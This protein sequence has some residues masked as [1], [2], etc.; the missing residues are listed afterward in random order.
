MVDYLRREQEM[1]FEVKDGEARNITVGFLMPCHSTPW[2]SHLVYPH[3]NAWAL[4]CEPPLHLSIAERESYLD[5]ADVFY[6]DPDLWLNANMK[7]R[8]DFEM[9]LL[10]DHAAEAAT[11]RAWPE[12]VVFF[13]QLEP[14]IQNVLGTSQ[15]REC[16]R[17]FNTHWH[18][19]WRRKGDIIVWCTR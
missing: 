14:T 10:P 17:G 12:Y 9:E 4:T 1:S 18:D 5:E 16:W 19:D 8:K 3:I 15:Y 13:E 7:T 6:N 11:R 2:R